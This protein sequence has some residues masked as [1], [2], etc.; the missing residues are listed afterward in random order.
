MRQSN[1]SKQLTKFCTKIN[2]I[3]TLSTYS[4]DFSITYFGN[5]VCLQKL[6]N[7]IP[8]KGLKTW[9]IVIFKKI[10]KC[11]FYEVIV[12]L[13]YA[14]IWCANPVFLYALILKKVAQ[15]HGFTENILQLVTCLKMM[16]KN[17]LINF[18]AFD[19]TNFLLRME[20]A[21][22]ICIFFS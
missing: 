16:M 21:F 11:W 19:I 6:S 17:I 10:P 9:E 5:S 22:T 2:T 18:Y 12:Q 8:R 20:Q 14:G 7:F 1:F 15:C 13:S 3:F 4:D